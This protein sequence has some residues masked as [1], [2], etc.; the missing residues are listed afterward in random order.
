MI[1]TPL[2]RVLSWGL[3]CMALLPFFGTAVADPVSAGQD[4]ETGL[5]FWQWQGEGVSLKLLQ[6]LPDQTRAFFLA[7]GF[8]KDAADAIGVGCVFQ[9]IF[10]N[11]APPSGGGAVNYDMGEWRV[12]HDAR[13]VPVKLKSEWDREWQDRGLSNSARIAFRWSL[14]PTRQQFEPGDYN[15]G[16]TTYDLPPGSLFDLEFAWHADGERHQGYLTGLQ[17]PMDTPSTN[18]QE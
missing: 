11:T 15:W 18:P 2:P 1:R 8:D 13:S 16:M 7:R 9:T 14:L 6:R 4:A 10:R 12:H 3:L 17:C 5:R